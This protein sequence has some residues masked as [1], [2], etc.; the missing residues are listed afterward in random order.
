MVESR[1]TGGIGVKSGDADRSDQLG[2]DIESRLD[3]LADA[4]GALRRSLPGADVTGRLTAQVDALPDT[5]AARLGIDAGTAALAVKIAGVA[6]AVE[7]SKLATQAGVDAVSATLE[8][9]PWLQELSARLD[10]VER[11]LRVNAEAEA[12]GRQ[13]AGARLAALEA[14]LADVVEGLET[15]G[16]RL[17]HLAAAVDGIGPRIGRVEVAVDATAAR[18]AEVAHTVDATAPQLDRLTAAV[19]SSGPRLDRLTAS[20]HTVGPRIDALAEAVDETAPQIDRLTAAVDAHRPLLERLRATAEATAMRLDEVTA[21]VDANGGPLDALAQRV[22]DA[23]AATEV[24]HRALAD[25]SAAVVDLKE[26]LRAVGAAVG[27]SQDETLLEELRALAAGVA[28]VVQ[29][30]VVDREAQEAAFSAIRADVAAATA[31]PHPDPAVV[32]AL[33]GLAAATD[34]LAH[35]LTLTAERLEHRLAGV[36]E[37]LGTL[38]RSALA[39]TADSAATLAM[40]RAERAVVQA[41]LE[42]ARRAT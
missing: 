29:A 3:A 28:D 27:R 10:G 38:E 17:E 35:L 19:D 20:V 6:S 13:A 25:H 4:I 22:S 34:D 1:E 40:L 42:E 41:Q 8:A 26:Q 2:S 16:P 23:T 24:V 30:S 12:T 14:R 36:Q 37:R 9:P 11:A 5:L 15:T 31:A 32:P 7:Q 21:T 39:E 18:L 33:D